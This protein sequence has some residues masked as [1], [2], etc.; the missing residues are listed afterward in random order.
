ME[1]VYIL[2]MAGGE[3]TRFAPLST[4][5]VPKQ[6]LNL[7]GEGTFIQ[8]TRLRIA[9]L[10]PADRIYVATNERYVDLVKA[11][12][13]DIPAE[14]IISEPVKRN[15]A[16]SIIYAA[17]LIQG[18]DPHAVIAVLPSD[19][20]ILRPERFLNAIRSALDH[21]RTSGTL[22][23]LGIMP[24]WPSTD[25]GYIMAADHP[26]PFVRGGSGRGR[27]CNVAESHIFQVSAFVEKPNSATAARYI[28]EGNFYWNSGMFV[29]RA[30]SLLSEV[31]IHLPDLHALLA[32]FTDSD[33]YRREY[34]LKARSISV[35]YGI[36]EK[37]GNV[38]VIPCDIGWSDI[39]TWEGLYN[40]Y[41]G[42]KVVIA[43]HVVAVMQKI[44]G[45]SI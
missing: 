25:Y 42:G 19:H 40:L 30:D 8:Q 13:N 16:P 29:W 23:T 45:D 11:Q 18:R 27:S 4:A 6:F 39:G 36:L 35:D 17:R 12:L 22:V 21:A 32:N 7:V 20:V 14:N 5:E 33:E 15:T 37:S 10:V 2:I 26:L 3:G 31:T 28:A 24:T 41:K 1:H 9:N 38:A 44:Q 34:F 43:P